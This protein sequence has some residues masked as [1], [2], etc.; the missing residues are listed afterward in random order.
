MRRRTLIAAAGTT[1]ASVLV[2]RG[3]R[4]SDSGGNAPVTV[5][6]D[7]LG[8]PVISEGRLRNYVFVQIRLILAPGQDQAALRAK[9]P[10]LRDALVKAAHRTPFTRPGDWSSL[11]AGRMAAA[12]RRSATALVGRG[13]V[14]NVE[15]TSQTPR[16]RLRPPAR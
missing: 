7:N 1:V 6:I 4:A 14:A 16:R 11:D 8:L 15:V 5:N 9:T 2:P 12:L 13:V 3:A 10:Y